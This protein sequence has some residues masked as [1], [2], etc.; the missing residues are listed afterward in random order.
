MRGAD[1]QRLGPRCRCHR[2]L[3]RDSSY[4]HGPDRP[5][6]C[7]SCLATNRNLS[8]FATTRRAAICSPSVWKNSTPAS[9]E[10][11]NPST[12]GSP[13]TST[14][15]CSCTS[16]N[17]RL[18]APA[19]YLATRSRPTTGRLAAA[20]FP[21]PSAVDVTS[22]VNIMTRPATS[23]LRLAVKNLSTRS[24]HCAGSGRNRGLGSPSR[25][26]ARWCNCRALASEVFSMSAICGGCIRTP[27]GERKRRVRRG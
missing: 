20:T 8:G 13:F 15:N 5:A 24:C 4:P 22:A 6:R 23:P 14:P 17:G 1:R 27:P 11:V 18:S 7:D 16:G 26:W 2:P 25:C 12:A 9:S 10:P 21:P 3:V 19:R